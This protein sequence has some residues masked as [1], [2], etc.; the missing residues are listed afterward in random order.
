MFYAADY[1]TVR[2]SVSMTCTINR[3]L[4]SVKKGQLGQENSPYTGYTVAKTAILGIIGLFFAPLWC[5]RRYG[6]GHCIP[7]S[8][9]DRFVTE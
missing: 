3:S 2:V 8:A 5:S 6:C 9:G 4:L 1:V 7:V